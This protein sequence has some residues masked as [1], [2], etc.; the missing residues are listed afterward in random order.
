MYAFVIISIS[1]QSYHYE[2]SYSSVQGFEAIN[3]LT[4]IYL[5]P[6]P[7]FGFG[8]GVGLGLAFVDVVA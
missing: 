3:M 4:H 6:F 8:V 5:V 2:N 7:F 1:R